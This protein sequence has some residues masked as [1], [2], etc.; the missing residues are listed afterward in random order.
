MKPIALGFCF[1][2]ALAT[3]GCG[4]DSPSGVPSGKDASGNDVS[5]SNKD[6][7][8]DLVTSSDSK[9]GAQSV[10]DA[11]TAEASR[12]LDAADATLGSDSTPDGNRIDG[13]GSDGEK[14]DT[15]R[16][17]DTAP[18]Q[19]GLEGG[20]VDAQIEI[21]FPCQGDSDCC[22]EIDA[23]MSDAYLYSK[24]PGAAAAPRIP[25][26]SMCTSCIPPAIQVRCVS[27]QCVGE[28]VAYTSALTVDH[29]GYLHKVDGGMTALQYSIDAGAGPANDGGAST[30]KSVWSCSGS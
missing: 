23:C 18:D 29:C 14:L 3:L 6:A 28:R 26:S 21:G 25:T 8:A 13:T 2:M 15:D 5:V 20:D 4:S 1:S 9:D 17:M 27:G 12:P 24:A 11:A 7:A 10:P 16:P 22:I 30:T 19:A